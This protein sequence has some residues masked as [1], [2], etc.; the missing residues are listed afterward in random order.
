MLTF[1]LVEMKECGLFYDTR[2]TCTPGKREQVLAGLK[3]VALHVEG[4]EPGTYTFLV[5]RSLDT[6]D[7]VRVF[8]RYESREVM[9]EHW[10]G[11]VLLQFL[12]ASKENVKSME[13]RA[14][15]PNGLGWLHR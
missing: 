11:E 15:V 8:E 3:K 7:G 12:M 10:K 6:E 4:H 5:L 13:G 9:E 2:I 1:V 14:Y